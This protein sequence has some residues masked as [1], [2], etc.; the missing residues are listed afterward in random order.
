VALSY[1]SGFGVLGISEQPVAYKEADTLLA[2]LSQFADLDSFAHDADPKLQ[3]LRLNLHESYRVCAAITRQHSKSFFFSSQLLPYEKRRAVRAFYAFCRT[4]DDIVDQPGEDL[5]RALASWVALVY[6][7]HANTAN[8][9]LSAWNDTVAR[10][11]IPRALVDELLAG[12]AMDLSVDR[13]A[14]FDEL[15]VYCYRVASV[16]GLISM[17]IVGHQP[18]AAEYAVKLGVALQLT[19]ILRDVGEDARRGRIYLPQEDLARF[20]LSDHDILTSNHTDAF[21]AMMRFQIARAHALYEQ[22]WPG[23]ALLHKDSRLAVGAASEIYR[24]ILGKIEQNDYNV[25]SQRAHVP[26]TEK[27]RILAHVWARIQKMK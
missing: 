19:N 26:F 10:H 18:G 5:A 17:Q 14:T 20:G 23:V 15:W 6:S 21:R 2:E 13:Y 24:A 12:I 9:V 16:V 11:A 25:F 1:R 3:P 4:S 8:P 7:P 22:S 27:L